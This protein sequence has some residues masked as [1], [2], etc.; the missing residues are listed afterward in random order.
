[1]S[2]FGNGYGELDRQLAEALRSARTTEEADRIARAD[3]LRDARDAADWLRERSPE[4]GSP[5]AEAERECRRRGR[6]R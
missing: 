2:D 6:S 5:R 3:G 4:P 1:M